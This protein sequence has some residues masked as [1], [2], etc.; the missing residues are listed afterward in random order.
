MLSEE[1]MASLEGDKLSVSLE[2]PGILIE[3]RFTK[4]P[5]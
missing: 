1:N 2:S 5:S 4:L 3:Q